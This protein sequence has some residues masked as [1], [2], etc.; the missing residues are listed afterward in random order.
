MYRLS[1]VPLYYYQLFMVLLYQSSLITAW[2]DFSGVKIWEHTLLEGYVHRSKSE[3]LLI[4][5]IE[6]DK[7]EA[8]D[9]CKTDRA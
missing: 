2:A 8:R 9:Y 3:G 1:I 4:S 5:E 6:I 7:K